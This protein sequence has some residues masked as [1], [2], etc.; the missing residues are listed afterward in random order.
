MRNSPEK[1]NF[2]NNKK[3]ATELNTEYDTKIEKFK[4]QLNSLTM[5]MHFDLDLP[6]DAAKKM[7]MNIVEQTENW[8]PKDEKYANATDS[9]K[10]QISELIEFAKNQLEISKESTKN[11]IKEIAREELDH[12]SFFS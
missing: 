10:Q 4:E 11:K 12:I 3:E 6:E 8:H 5:L 9:F 7:I 1:I 2:E